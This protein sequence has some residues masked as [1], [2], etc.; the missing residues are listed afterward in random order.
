ME[1]VLAYWLGDW[2]SSNVTIMASMIYCIACL[3]LAWHMVMP[4]KEQ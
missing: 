3:A 1:D 4:E 2:G